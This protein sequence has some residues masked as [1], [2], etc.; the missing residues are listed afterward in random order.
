L[1]VPKDEILKE[2]LLRYFLSA[3]KTR[4]F[5]GFI[6]EE[7]PVFDS[8]K[9]IFENPKSFIKESKK[10]AEHLYEVSDHPWIKNGELYC[11]HFD[12]LK[13]EGEEYELW[14][15]FKSENK[16]QFLKIYQSDNSFRMEADKE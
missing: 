5:H 9:S 14:S 4:E 10:L 15:V 11:V 7:N 1:I 2:L 13:F 16:E 12:G 3:F 8:V 6:E